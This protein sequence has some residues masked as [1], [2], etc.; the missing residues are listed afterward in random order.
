MW[1]RALRASSAAYRQTLGSTCTNLTR[2]RSGESH[3]L[4]TQRQG[5]A[6]RDGQQQLF[7]LLCR[8]LHTSS[9]ACKL[10]LGSACRRFRRLR[11]GRAS[12]CHRCCWILNDG[13][14]LTD[15][16][17][18]TQRLSC[19]KRRA[20]HICTA[21]CKRTSASTC[22]SLSRLRSGQALECRRASCIPPLCR[23]Q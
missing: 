8:A 4:C 11:S 22:R 3:D 2:Q 17:A 20:L 9:A 23:W 19:M 15:A 12:E 7:C 5:T 14:F 18:E 21:V 1:C 10:T 13:R 16:G 6:A